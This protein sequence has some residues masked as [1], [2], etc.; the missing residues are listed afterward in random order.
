MKASG[1]A[2][3]PDFFFRGRWGSRSAAWQAGKRLLWLG[4]LSQLLSRALVG[5]GGP[6]KKH[7]NEVIF[8]SMI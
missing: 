5:G 6:W 8:R 2:T 4:H 7:E 3:T 1:C